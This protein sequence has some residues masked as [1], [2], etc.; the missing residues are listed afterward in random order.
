MPYTRKGNC[1]YKETGKKMGCSKDAAAAEKYMKALYAAE[2]GN[3][4]EGF[5]PD[6][7]DPNEPELA[8]TVE[9]PNPTKLMASFISTLFSSRTQAHIFHLQVTGPGSFAAHKALNE[10]YDEIVGLADDI[11]E[12]YQGRYSIITGYKGE[13]QWIE[14][15]TQ[16]VKYFEA[17]CMYVEKNRVSLVQDSYIQNQ[18][19]EVVALIES[20]KYKL[21]KLM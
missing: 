16:V 2:Q 19:D 10:Y 3:I 4:K 7:I 1:V 14:D 8:V 20:T 21:S 9:L 15:I 12:S 11:V 5:E 6:T 13:G 17:L 18:I